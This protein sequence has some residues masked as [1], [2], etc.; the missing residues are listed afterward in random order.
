MATLVHDRCAI[1]ERDSLQ[2]PASFVGPL[3]VATDCSPASDAALRMTRAIVANTA[4]EV[5]VLAVVPPMPM[6][7]PEMQMVVPPSRGR[8]RAGQMRQQVL[9][10]LYRTGVDREW[11]IAIGSGDPAATI[12]KAARDNDASLVIMG[13]GE[14][15][16]FDR[17]LGDETVLRVLRLGSVPVLAVAP[18]AER[19]P[20]RV[21]A[22]IDFT[23]SS[24][25]AAGLA[26]RIMCPKGQLTLAHVLSREVDPANWTS[27]N[28]PFEGTM[29]RAFDLAVARIGFGN[30]ERIERRVTAGDP[31]RCLA[32][33]ADAIDTD[34]LVVGSHG[35]NF[36]TRLRLGSVSE[37]MVR[38]ASCSVLIAPPEDGPNFLD[39]VPAATTRFASYE[40]SERLEDFTR[41]NASRTATLEVIDPDLGAQV[42]QKGFP[43]VGASFDPRD[44]RVQ[45]MMGEFAP[46]GRHLTRSISGVTAVQVLR[47]RAGRDMLLR[48]AHG[49]GQT[50]LT[51]D[52]V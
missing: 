33:L 38:G 40:W 32:A 8:E 36:L 47:D 30:G 15:G 43:F 35:R 17:L 39:E 20:R 51:L 18:G 42:E 21:L 13:L 31:T 24:V 6:A 14:H 25:R 10:Q 7:A 27:V 1:P 12:V 22:G 9:E 16:L 44:G 5:I 26:A 50:L 52:R 37:R 23:S 19:L 28:A 46:R 4:R 29:G 3:L 41:R 45:I 2:E 34:L 11:R 48:V 49:R